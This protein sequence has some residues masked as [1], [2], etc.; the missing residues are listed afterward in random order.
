MMITIN[1]SYSILNVFT[2]KKSKLKK[3]FYPPKKTI[4]EVFTCLWDSEVKYHYKK[5]Q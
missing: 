5:Q 3:I 1:E 4:L 2:Y